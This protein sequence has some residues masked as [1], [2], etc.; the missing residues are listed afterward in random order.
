MR[1]IALDVG[2]KRIGVAS[3]DLS[4]TIASPHSV[5]NRI[6]FSKDVLAIKKIYDELDA[7]L[8]VIGLPRNMDGSIGFQSEKVMMLVEK[9]NEAG[10]NTTLWDER[11]TTV[12]ANKALIEGN[13]RREDRRYTV[14][15]IAASIILQSYLDSN[16]IKRSQGS[17]QEEK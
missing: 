13:M 7:E 1:L 10:L 14:D 4:Q 9:L 6:G 17:T 11:L 15:K 16:K 12:I 2:D 8:I 5:I 3:S